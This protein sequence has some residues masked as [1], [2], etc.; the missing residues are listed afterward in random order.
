MNRVLLVLSC[1]LLAAAP[2]YAQSAGAQAE[3]L[4][5]Q[6]RQLMTAGKIGEACSAFA[7]SEKLDPA[8]T[9]LLN[10]AECREK[11]GQVA[12]AWGLFLDAERQTRDAT[13]PVDTKLHQVALEHAKQLE[14]RVSKLTIEVPVA[15]RR[16]QLQITRDSE[17][18][19][20][21]MWDR[22]SPIDGGA[23]TITVSAPGATTWSTTVTVAPEDDNKTIIV[24]ALA[25]TATAAPEATSNA[26]P[27]MTTAAPTGI[28]SAVPR[29]S[30][31]SRVL[32][33]ALGATAVAMLGGSLAFDLWGDSTYNQAK[34]APDQTRADD[35]WHS[36]NTKRYVA[37]GL[38]VAGVGCAA[39]AVWRF[40]ANRGDSPRA[41]RVSIMPVV[42]TRQFGLALSRS[43]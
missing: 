36:A 37:E 34:T 31:H 30:G 38:A 27:T 41:E 9:T 6:G 7:E 2:V 8:V 40:M 23:H 29:P 11:N 14:P 35:L 22:P 25:S 4:F 42:T 43:W 3:V 18:L 13:S 10:L 24:P 33:I 28:V 17:Q 5:R 1:S 39:V 15:S 19:A 32:P 16:P 21:V 12:T 20:P 26:H